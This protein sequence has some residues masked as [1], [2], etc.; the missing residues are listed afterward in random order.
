MSEAATDPVHARA[1][2]DISLSVWATHDGLTCEISSRSWPATRA[3]GESELP[4]DVDPVMLDRLQ[5]VRGLFGDAERSE[6]AGTVRVRFST[7]SRG[8]P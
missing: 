2:G 3:V 1:G 4:E 7:A 8:T 6:E 5:L